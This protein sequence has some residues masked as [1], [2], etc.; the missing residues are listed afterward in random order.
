MSLRSVTR[1]SV[2]VLLAVLMLWLTGC[3]AGEARPSGGAGNTE[4]AT[5]GKGFGSA[6]QQ[7]AAM[8]SDAAPGVFPRTIKHAN[9]TTEIK[10]KPQRVVVLDTGELDAAVSLGVIPVGLSTNEGANPV[11][12]YLAPQVIDARRVGEMNN[13]NLE[14]I[15]AL[16]PDLILSSKLRHDKLYPQLSQIAPTV[17]SVRPGYTWKE[18]FRLAA[19]ALGEETRGDAVMKSYDDAAA[20]LKT[21][22]GANPPKVSLVRFMPGKLRLYANKPLIGV[23]L[24]DAGFQRPENQNVDELAVEISPE[25]ISQADADLVF[26]SSYG[27]PGATGETATIEGAGWKAL[28]AVQQGRAHRVSDD[29]WFLGLGP[30]GAQAILADLQGFVG[31]S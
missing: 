27:D 17:F 3:A 26:W 13:L 11:P 1:R 25:N 20:A 2:P 21:K 29:T 19:D 4:V 7:T 10:Q 18:N 6:E 15:A 16:K 9:G 5:G 28:P 31:A 8:G 30:T 23:I 12:S 24:A 14:A 22:V